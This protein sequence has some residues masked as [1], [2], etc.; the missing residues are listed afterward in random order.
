MKGLET[1]R[2]IFK[3]EGIAFIV[4][5]LALF[6]GL[7]FLSDF[8]LGAIDP[9]GLIY[10]PVMDRLSVLFEILSGSILHTAKALL[11]LCNKH[12]IIHNGRW[13]IGSVINI[14]GGTGYVI[15]G[16]P[17]LGIGVFSFWIAFVGAQKSSFT[18]KLRWLTVGVV[19][20]WFLNVLRIFF[21]LL[22]LDGHWR[23][24]KYVDHH[25]VFNCCCYVLIFLLIFI[26]TRQLKK[27]AVAYGNKF[28]ENE[29]VEERSKKVEKAV[30]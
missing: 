14:E 20:I 9:K 22:A 10:I 12:S 6:L 19:G 1:I 18:N 15:F 29:C 5:F 28:V 7:I 3:N 13:G 30:V 11:L 26:Y 4:K 8:I 24:L 17:C 2:S 25:F 21:L 27:E 23:Q 16:Y